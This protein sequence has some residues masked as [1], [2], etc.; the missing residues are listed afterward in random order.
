M[1]TGCIC[2]VYIHKGVLIQNDYNTYKN[3]IATGDWEHTEYIGTN[4]T[5]KKLE[6][7]SE[8]KDQ[9]ES[10]QKTKT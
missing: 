8:K 3:Y 10:Q 4:V 1:G 7:H 5:H 2:L 9:L 6:A